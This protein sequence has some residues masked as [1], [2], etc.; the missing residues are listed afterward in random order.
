MLVFN[1]SYHR[2]ATTSFHNYMEQMGFKSMHNVS[3][4]LSKV[5]GTSN[6]ILTCEDWDEVALTADEFVERYAGDLVKYIRESEFNVFSD[7]PYPLFYKQLVGEFPDAK[8]ILFKRDSYKWLHSINTY[9]GE[10]YTYFRRILY[11]SNEDV[12]YWR[13]K[14]EEHN[15][16]V[17]NYFY[18]QGIPLL[19]VDMDD[20]KDIGR[21]LNDFLEIPDKLKT[22][23]G[24]RSNLDEVGCKQGK[25]LKFPLLNQIKKK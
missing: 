7:N 19:I 4:T 25:R 20:N 14:Y 10:T 8:F 2:N 16:S 9:F 6:H 3:V 24:R 11:D 5:T 18:D 1:L 17:A 15:N 21:T 13:K 22:S 12:E 23:G